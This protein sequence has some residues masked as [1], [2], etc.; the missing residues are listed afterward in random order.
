MFDNIYSRLDTMH[1]HDG[2][3]DGRTPDDSKHR[4]S[5]AR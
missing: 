1:E 5:V 2:Q 4:A 3:M